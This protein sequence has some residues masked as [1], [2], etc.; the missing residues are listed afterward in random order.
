MGIV[1]RGLGNI[2]EAEKLYQQAYQL[3]P[4]NPEP[5]INLAVLEADYRNEYQDAFA[6]LDRYLAE[7]GTNTDLEKQWRS[8][9]EKSEKDFLEEQRRRE[10]RERFKRRQEA[11]RKKAEE[12]RAAEEAQRLAEEQ[13]AQEADGQSV[14]DIE[15]PAGT[16]GDSEESGTDTVGNEGEESGVE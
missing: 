10:M 7:G 3:S 5:L 9:F 2:D 1:Q 11:A 4:N 8:E 15:E 16:E 6:Y 14:D 12:A 13:A